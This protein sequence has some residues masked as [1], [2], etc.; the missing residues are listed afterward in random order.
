MLD[1]DGDGQIA[2]HELLS[3]IKEAFA[4]RELTSAYVHAPYHQLQM[5]ALSSCS[6]HA[7]EGA[8]R[9]HTVCSMRGNRPI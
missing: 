1:V 6:T 8:Q 9:N 3:S 4:A 2:F 5:H 7:V